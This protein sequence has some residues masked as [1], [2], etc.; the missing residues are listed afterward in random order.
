MKTIHI[1]LISLVLITLGCPAE[2]EPPVKESLYSKLQNNNNSVT[3]AGSSDGTG[4]GGIE[5]VLDGGG[6]G[7]ADG[8]GDGSETTDAGNTVN[9]GP[10]NGIDVALDFGTVA[11]G[12]VEITMNSGVDIAGFQFSFSGAAIA[13]HSGGIVE[14]LPSSWQVTTAA[15]GT[16]LGFK[17]SSDGDIEPVNDVLM[18]L[19]VGAA[20]ENEFCISDVTFSD[21]SG[22]ALVASPGAD[23]TKCVTAP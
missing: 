19:S 10:G 23:E 2:E 18:I 7:S 1:C 3:D 5:G 11:A 6:D 21:A 15:T 12:S 14:D 4:E 9:P 8:S 20:S 17:F 13:S 16:V 22:T